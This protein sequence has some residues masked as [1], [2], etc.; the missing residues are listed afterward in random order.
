MAEYIERKP[1]IALMREMEKQIA[2]C[3]IRPQLAGAIA[4]ELEKSET[5]V[6][7]RWEGHDESTYDAY[8]HH[9]CT[10]CKAD[11]PFGYKMREDWDEG[12]NGEWYSLGMIDDGINEHLTPYC[13]NCGCRM[14][15]EGE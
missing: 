7:G 6:H 14:D 8:W 10:N 4:E 9:R 12:M 3:H 1:L 13:P 15:K 5:V 11:A 2:L